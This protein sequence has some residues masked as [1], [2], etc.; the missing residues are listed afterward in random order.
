MRRA[1]QIGVGGAGSAVAHAALLLG[2]GE[3]AL[4]DAVPERAERGAAS[5]NA[6][7]GRGRV[8]AVTEL[9]PAI[10]EADGLIHCTPTGMAKLPGMAVPAELLRPGLWVAE[11]VY[12]PLVTEL[13]RTARERGCRVADGSG[14]AVFQAVDAFRLFTAITPDAARMAAHFKEWDIP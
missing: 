11:I 4:Y 2:I 10:A 6:R 1:V 13:V 5:L 8:R 9:A 12:L 3:L 7:F 14:M